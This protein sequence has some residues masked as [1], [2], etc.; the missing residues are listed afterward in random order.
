MHWIE[1]YTLD[2]GHHRNIIIL[3]LEDPSLSWL[4]VSLVHSKD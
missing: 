2:R 3:G 4:V 1:V